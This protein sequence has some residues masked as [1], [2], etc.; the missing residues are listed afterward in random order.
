MIN[1]IFSEFDE[2]TRCLRSKHKQIS[3]ILKR[4]KNRFNI[5]EMENKKEQLKKCMLDYIYSSD[6]E[7]IENYNEYEKPTYVIFDELK[8]LSVIHSI[9]Y[10]KD[11]I[12]IISNYSDIYDTNA[13][14]DSY[15]II[16]KG[17]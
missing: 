1:N 17:E 11:Y 4:L 6:S 14:V 8:E 16:V 10:R 9:F 7:Y 5:N 2:V 13:G 12:E 15:R 3:E